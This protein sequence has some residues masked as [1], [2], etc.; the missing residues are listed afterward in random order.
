MYLFI[1]TT[2]NTLLTIALYDANARCV[3]KEEKAIDRKESEHLLPLIKKITTEKAAKSISGIVVVKGPAG[4]FSAIRTGVSVANALAFA[5]NV[6]VVGIEQG[7][8]LEGAF[9][10]IKN[11]KEFT[12]PV[13]AVYAQEPNIR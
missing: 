8:S 9:K 5:W 2:H 1:D 13:L 4:R 6:P 7:E 3:K 11:K 12:K 10:E